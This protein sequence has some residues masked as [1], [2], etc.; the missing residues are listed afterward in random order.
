MMPRNLN[1][2]VELLFP[3]ERK[4]HIE[5]VKEFLDLCLKDNVGAHVMLANGTWRRAYPHGR[6]RISVQAALMSQAKAP[7]TA[8][9]THGPQRMTA[10]PIL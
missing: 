4:A 6:K 10:P 7:G 2:R 5:R 1:D 8:A 9:E 3:V